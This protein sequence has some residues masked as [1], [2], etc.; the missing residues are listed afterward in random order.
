MGKTISSGLKNTTPLP[1][2]RMAET[3]GSLIDKLTIKALREFHLRERRASSR[4][5][6]PARKLSILKKQKAALGDEIDVFLKLA[7]AGKVSLT[8]EKL[9]LYNKP[10]VMGKTG[11][12]KSLAQAIEGLAEQNIKLWHLEDEAR[13]EDKGLAFVGSIKR[14]I[15]ITNQKRNDFIDL[16]DHLLKEYIQRKDSRS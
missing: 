6:E 13:R 9:K 3:L 4:E 12:I 5:K 1:S 14:K 15:D 7:L 10:E 2:N 16:I 8:D 11:N